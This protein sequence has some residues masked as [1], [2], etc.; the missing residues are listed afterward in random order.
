MDWL[1]IGVGYR[2]RG[3]N[4]F[5]FIERIIMATRLE[6]SRTPSISL[7]VQHIRHSILPVLLLG[8]EMTE[9][10]KIA[11]ISTVFGTMFSI[12]VVFCVPR[13][14]N[15]LEFRILHN[16]VQIYPRMPAEELIPSMRYGQS[17]CHSSRD[18]ASFSGI[19]AMTIYNVGYLR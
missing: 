15:A 10:I 7:Y 16:P 13:S 5:V 3:Q 6:S 14:E 12:E 8:L 18:R 1:T 2:Q 19:L 4:L 9:T 17:F 11:L